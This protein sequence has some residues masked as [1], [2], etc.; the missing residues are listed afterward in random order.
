ML[1][2]YR[3]EWQNFAF[4][5]VR[6][7][8]SIRR[9][10]AEE[11]AAARDLQPVQRVEAKAAAIEVASPPKGHDHAGAPPVLR[12]N[13]QGGLEKE[14]MMKVILCIYSFT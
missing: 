13:G 11:G 1:Y 2:L 7:Q 3:K 5:E 14:E 12:S 6:G 8:T 9:E 4:A 10:E